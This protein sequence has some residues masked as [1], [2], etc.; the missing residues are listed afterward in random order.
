MLTCRGLV[1]KV[2]ASHRKSMQMRASPFDKPLRLSRKRS[3]SETLKKPDEFENVNT[4]FRFRVDGK[5]LE[6][7]KVGMTIIT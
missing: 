3:F 7:E 1:A 4:A 6:N 2:S 5:H